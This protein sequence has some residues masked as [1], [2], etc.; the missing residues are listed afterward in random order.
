[1]LPWVLAAAT[2]FTTLIAG[3]FLAPSSAQAI[4]RLL[5]DPGTLVGVLREVGLTGFLTR[6]G[7]TMSRAWPYAMA[8]LAF[9]LAHEM[10]HYLACRFHGVDCTLPYFLPGPP[11][12]GTFGAVIRIRSPFPHRRAL[13]DIGIAGPLAGFA[14]M[15]PI[16][17]LGV[18]DL[19]A[20]AHTPL[21]PGTESIY[22]GDSLLTT[23]LTRTLRPEVGPDADLLIS[24]L[25]VAGWFA[26]LATA[27]NLI[28]AGQ[29][30]GGH[31]FYALFPRW[32]RKLSLASGLALLSLVLTIGLLRQQ[33]SAWTVWAFVVLL[34]GRRHPP[35]PDDGRPLGAWRWA[36]AVTV[37]VVLV[38]CFIPHPIGTTTG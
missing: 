38:A 18:L 9:F 35:V 1:M 20:V 19:E 34:F 37:L 33:F 2:V 27:M 12:I 24:P 5:A 25:F 13:F 10:G 32:H 8:I 4:D 11:P 16:L 14:V 7:T 28:P 21:P 22:F 23:L 17:A 31:I 29:F 26:M 15:L 30:D 6:I 3:I 36:L